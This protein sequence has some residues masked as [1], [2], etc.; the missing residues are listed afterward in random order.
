MRANRIIRALLALGGSGTTQDITAVV[1][2]RPECVSA[3]LAG[4]ELRGAV[5]RRGERTVHV[6]RWHAG[7]VAVR[8]AVW[9]IR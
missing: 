5:T 9:V 4:M 1:R 8:A 3:Q 2:A 6:R 7:T